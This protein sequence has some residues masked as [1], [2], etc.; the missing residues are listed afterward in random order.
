MT[1]YSPKASTYTS[2]TPYITIDEYN[3]SPTGV[4]VSQLVPRGTLQQNTDALSIAIERASSYADVYC[5]QVLAATSD[6]EAGRYRINR[7]GQVR[8]PVERSPIISVSGISIGF[9]PS[10][11]TALTDLSNVWI[12]RKALMFPVSTMQ[13][14]PFNS[15]IMSDGRLFV[16]VNYVNGYAN[17]LT[18]AASVEGA[19]TLTVDSTL[20]LVPGMAVTVYDPAFTEQANVVSTTATTITLDSA[21]TYAHAAGTSVS[22][23]PPAVKQAVVLLTSALIKTR[24]SEAIVM[25]SM[26]ATPSSAV[27]SESGALEEIVLAKELLAPYVRVV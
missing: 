15:Q 6:V 18:T 17:T 24:G 2:R 21:L 23:M 19:T 20:G 14:Q 10:A 5:R 9:A 11:M 26:R 3:A 7:Y 22:V 1:V 13:L 16:T 25:N 27:T 8:V 4:N 12:E